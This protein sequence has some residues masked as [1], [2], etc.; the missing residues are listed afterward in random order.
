MRALAD[1]GGSVA[2]EIAS[3][4]AIFLGWLVWSSRLEL[5]RL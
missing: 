2:A 4:R 1:R 3:V 5:E